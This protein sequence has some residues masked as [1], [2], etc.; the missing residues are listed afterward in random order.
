MEQTPDSRVLTPP[1]SAMKPVDE[2]TDRELMEEIVL[3]MR[4]VGSAL[5][6][7]QTMG[8]MGMMKMMMGK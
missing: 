3:S 4:T 1:V 7:F 2:M 6:Q 5:A 8:P